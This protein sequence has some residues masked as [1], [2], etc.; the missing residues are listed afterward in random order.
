MNFKGCNIMSNEKLKSISVLIVDDD[1]DIINAMKIMISR[2]V[3][4]VYTASNGKDGLESYK[5]NNPDMVISDIRMPI[6]NGL[7]MAKAIK[8]ISPEQPVAILSAHNDTNLFLDS[9]DIGIDKYFLKPLKVDALIKWIKYIS[10]Q[11]ITRKELKIQE[12]N[13]HFIMNH[14]PDGI[15]MIDGDKISYLNKSFLKLMNLDSFEN[16]DVD[17][18]CIVKCIIDEN[19]SQRFKDLDELKQFLNNQENENNIVRI[20]APDGSDDTIFF[21]NLFFKIYPEIQRIIMIFTDITNIEQERSLFKLQ[22]TTDALTQIP[23]RMYFDLYLDRQIN[24]ARREKTIFSLL[25]FDIDDF[26]VVNDT[27]GHPTGDIV[28]IELI[29]LVKSH[30]RKN[31]FLARW[32][33]EEFMILSRSNTKDSEIL[34]KK[35]L[36]EIRTHKFKI[37]GKV[38][39][40]F[41][42]SSFK[43][44]STAKTL[45]ENVDKALYEAKSDGKDCAK[46][47]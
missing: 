4:T 18:N 30:I 12:E 20:L 6:L 9:I 40:S 25:M 39:C 27:Y 38:T 42:I 33:G 35:L 19:G 11:I 21:Y 32:G 15:C 45:L 44:G 5:T 8:E 7:E 26:K 23:N 37:V 29:K 41:G 3:E 34:S 31:D 47:R 22:A 17:K 46:I 24:S 28:L 16:F 43:I 36:H 2:I 13:L 14:N 10:K 1:S